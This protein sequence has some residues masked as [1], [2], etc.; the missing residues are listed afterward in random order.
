MIHAQARTYYKKE[1]LP[2]ESELFD[3]V[4]DLQPLTQDCINQMLL[5]QSEI[6]SKQM[7]DEIDKL[8]KVQPAGHA[9]DARLTPPLNDQMLDQSNHELVKTYDNQELLRSQLCWK[10]QVQAQFRCIEP[11]VAAHVTAASQG[12]PLLALSY[13]HGLLTTGFLE[14]SQA[15]VVM[16]K[17]LRST[18]RL[19]NLSAHF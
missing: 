17:K 13:F 2:K 6:Y 5:D 11:E 19:G 4:V 18:L 1:I 8:I 12:N 14:I 9:V 10:Y 7:L 15:A 3:Q 16:T